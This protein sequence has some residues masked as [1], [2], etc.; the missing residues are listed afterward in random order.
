MELPITYHNETVGKLSITQQGLYYQ[1]AAACTVSCT[2]PL[3][4]YAVCGFGSKPI[5][6]LSKDGILK[7]RISVRETGALP[8]YAVLGNTDA[9]FFPWCGMLEGEKVSDAYLKAENGQMLLALPVTDGGEVPLIAYA[10]QMTPVTVCGRACLQLPLV[11]SKP[12]LPEPPEEPE[13]REEPEQ[14]DGEATQVPAPD[15]MFFEVPEEL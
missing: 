8:T 14:L 3:R 4:L 7:K 9:G 1:F 10:A 6:V 13:L 12:V 2:E 5:G 11:D 15:T